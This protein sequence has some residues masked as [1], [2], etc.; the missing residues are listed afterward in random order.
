M[1]LQAFRN[2]AVV[3]EISVYELINEAAS[4]LVVVSEIS[5]Y[6]HYVDQYANT[7]RFVRD[8]S[9][10]ANLFNTKMFSN[11]FITRCMYF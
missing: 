9:S 4:L 8:S 5:V 11:L 7:C 6:G 10:N 2:V 3:S 1:K